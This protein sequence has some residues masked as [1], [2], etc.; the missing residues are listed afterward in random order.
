M[1][2]LRQDV[3]IR[4]PATPD[5]GHCY[6]QQCFCTQYTVLVLVKNFVE[7]RRLQWQWCAQQPRALCMC[8][9]VTSYCCSKFIVSMTSETEVQCTMHTCRCM[10]ITLVIRMFGKV[11]TLPVCIH[12]RHTAY[13]M[14]HKHIELFID[15]VGQA[16]TDRS[17]RVFRV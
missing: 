16:E 13:L 17:S 3:S 11:C 1:F 15:F 8:R 7:V 5:R 2:R 4:P 10:V 9:L 12:K 6:Q 14:K